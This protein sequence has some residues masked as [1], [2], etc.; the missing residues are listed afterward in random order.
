MGDASRTFLH[1]APLTVTVSCR[2]VTR[3]DPSSNIVEASRE[4]TWRGSVH[5]GIGPGTKGSGVAWMGA[6]TKKP[7][8]VGE[9]FTSLPAS[10]P[11]CWLA[12]KDLRGATACRKLGESECRWALG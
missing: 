12:G 4:S 5:S 7:G 2:S 10:R 8:G 3:R 6:H 1:T 9:T 11:S